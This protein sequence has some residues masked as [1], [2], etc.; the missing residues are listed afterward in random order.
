VYRPERRH[1]A[2]IGNL[3]WDEY[4]C[5]STISACHRS[6]YP[7]TMT[8]FHGKFFLAGACNSSM[9]RRVLALTTSPRSH[10]SHTIIDWLTHNNARNEIALRFISFFSRFCHLCHSYCCFLLS[11]VAVRIAVFVVC[12]RLFVLPFF[13][14]F[15][16][17]KHI[18]SQCMTHK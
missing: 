11:F 5:I 6:S 3:I 7:R 14:T 15:L 18:C 8:L 9:S 12:C 10:V 16:L 2:K 4:G 13:D 17:F 1:L